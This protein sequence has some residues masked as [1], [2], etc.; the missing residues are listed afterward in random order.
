MRKN[1]LIKVWKQLD[2]A[3]E[4]LERLS[5]D[6]QGQELL[7]NHENRIDFSAIVNLKNDVEVLIESKTR[8]KSKI[9]GV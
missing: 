5:Y 9:K 7:N 6:D 4:A 8:S 2:Q 3:L 1:H